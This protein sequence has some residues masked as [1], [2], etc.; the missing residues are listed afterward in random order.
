MQKEK[1]YKKVTMLGFQRYFNWKGNKDKN[2]CI[3]KGHLK[4]LYTIDLNT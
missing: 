1:S 2:I 4:M 3:S